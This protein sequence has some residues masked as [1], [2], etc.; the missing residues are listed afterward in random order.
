MRFRDGNWEI[1]ARAKVS[2]YDY[3]TQTVSATDTDLRRKTMVSLGLRVERKLTKHLKAHASYNWDRSL[4][5]LEFDDYEASVVMGGLA[6][7]F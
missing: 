5:N 4:S 3:S 6:L 1:T 2:Y 7:M